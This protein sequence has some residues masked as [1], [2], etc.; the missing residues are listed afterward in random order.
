MGTNHDAVLI[1]IIII[2]FVIGLLAAYQYAFGDRT[3]TKSIQHDEKLNEI[4]IRAGLKVPGFN[5]QKYVE[6]NINIYGVSNMGVS[7]DER[8]IYLY[9]Y[10]L[11]GI[12][13]DDL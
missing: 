11:T 4:H 13:D 12:E 7:L 10:E 9:S 8:E 6:D 1:G 3:R 2:I 5:R